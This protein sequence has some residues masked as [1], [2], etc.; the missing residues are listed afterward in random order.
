MTVPA[1]VVELCNLIEDTTDEAALVQTARGARRIVTEA[2]RDG[3]PATKLAESWSTLVRSTVASAARFGIP[4]SS[5]GWSWYVSGSTAR[6]E[7]LPGSDVESILVLDDPRADLRAAMDSAGYVHSVLDRCGLRGDDK[8]AVASRARFCRTA[9]QWTE[10]IDAWTNDPQLD[11]G[12]VMAGLLADARSVTGDSDALRHSL[13]EVIKT[14]ERA[15]AAM[16][17]DSLFVRAALPSRLRLFATRDDVVDLK[18]AAIEPV[19]SIARWAALSSGSPTLATLDRLRDAS[20]TK[21][22]STDD[23][24]VLRECYTIST[25]MRWHHRAR[26]WLDAGPNDSRVTDEVTLSDL[27]PQDRALLRGVGREISG[28]RR[29]LAYLASTSTFTGR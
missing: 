19:V 21:F 20:G 29:K 10:G 14:R 5:A 4:P 6:N 17:S 7:A 28:I 18:A 11:R 9:V 27:P 22:L 15:L 3:M 16:L 13:A 12:V 8:G 1:N 23:A 2:Q 26:L 25:R 24:Q